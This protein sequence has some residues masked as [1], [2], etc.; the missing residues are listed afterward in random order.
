M[1]QPEFMVKAFG[2]ARSWLCR[3]AEP[4]TADLESELEELLVEVWRQEAFEREHPFTCA[5]IRQA[6]SSHELSRA[7]QTS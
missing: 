7:Q 3:R 1:H 4:P 2:A 5:V 6:S